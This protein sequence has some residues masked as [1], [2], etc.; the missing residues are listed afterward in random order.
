MI[1]IIRV[2]CIAIGGIY[3]INAAGAYKEKRIDNLIWNMG[4]AILMAICVMS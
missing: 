2:L 4:M 3:L 1:T